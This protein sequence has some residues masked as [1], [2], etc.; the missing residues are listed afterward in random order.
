MN[1][2]DTSQALFTLEYE[3]YFVGK[4]VGTMK[5]NTTSQNETTYWEGAL[6][7]KGLLAGI[8]VGDSTFY[9]QGHLDA[10]NNQFTPMLY[11]FESKNVPSRNVRYQFG[12]NKV[13]I[14][15]KQ[16]NLLQTKDLPTPM[17]IKDL[18]SLHLQLAIDAKQGQQEMNYTLLSKNKLEPYSFVVI[19]IETIP[20]PLVNGNPPI[21]TLKLHRLKN[22]QVRAHYWLSL[23]DNYLPIQVQTLRKNKP[24][25]EL[26]AQKIVVHKR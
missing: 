25:F 19:G 4:S 21:K 1:K 9:G 10:K 23:Q 2:T 12:R 7:S 6:T 3:V 8:I 18:F 26:R 16:N 11:N 15:R 5:I 13:S 20:S 14:T 22:N 24:Q 17:G